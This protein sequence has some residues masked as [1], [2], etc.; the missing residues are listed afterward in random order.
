MN[1]LQNPYLPNNINGGSVDDR[2]IQSR[3]AVDLLFTVNNP[4]I[5]PRI[6][7]PGFNQCQKVV[8]DTKCVPNG[9]NVNK[10]ELSCELFKQDLLDVDKHY[11]K[12]T[13]YYNATFG[14]IVEKKYKSSEEIKNKVK[15]I[16]DS[17]NKELNLCNISDNNS[18]NTQTI[19]LL[20]SLS[21]NNITAKNEVIQEI[22]N[23]NP[24]TPLNDVKKQ[25]N[26]INNKIKAI[27]EQNNRIIRKFK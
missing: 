14:D 1:Y 25:L 7:E 11:D 3:V 6:D 9:L 8:T 4:Y 21:T 18:N 17:I 24:I 10:C 5:K 20:N 16:L 2:S 13:G 27:K 19:T 23:I 12:I 15:P 22:K 26:D